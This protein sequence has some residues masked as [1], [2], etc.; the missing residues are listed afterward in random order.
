[1]VPMAASRRLDRAAL[2]YYPL[3]HYRSK[4]FLDGV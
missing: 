4:D 3:V 1:M 2:K